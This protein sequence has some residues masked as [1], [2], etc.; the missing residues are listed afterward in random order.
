MTHFTAAEE[1]AVKYWK[2]AEGSRK[3]ERRYR[4]N[5]AAVA[6]QIVGKR[7]GGTDRLAKLLGITDAAIEQMAAG[8][9][10][11]ATLCK[12]DHRRAWKC[13]R[14]YS[15][16]R[17]Y[18]VGKKWLEYELDWGDLWDYLD[19][20]LETSKAVMEITERHDPRPAWERQAIKDLPRLWHYVNDF[21]RAPDDV[22]H[23]A[24]MLAEAL[25]RYVE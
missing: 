22:R 1:R 25:E 12:L 8:Y 19:S 20:D 13:R 7:D 9:A 11:F 16:H 15:Y 5:T 17:F 6:G 2:M 21:D 4:W 18:S 10:I 14:E 24:K 3:D 23:A